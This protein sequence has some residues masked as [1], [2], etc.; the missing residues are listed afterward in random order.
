MANR[1]DNIICIDDSMCISKEN[2][3]DSNATIMDSNQ[4]CLSN[5]SL[6]SCN[7]LNLSNHFNNSKHDKIDATIDQ[8]SIDE[9][10]SRRTY[11]NSTEMLNVTDYVTNMLNKSNSW[12]EK[13]K[14]VKIHLLKFCP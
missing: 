12:L 7:E 5:E 4:S 1:Q 3:D 9:S 13:R 11:F 2:C 6:K 14:L 8:H 10:T